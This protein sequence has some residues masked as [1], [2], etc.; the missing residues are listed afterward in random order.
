MKSSVKSVFN[1]I[2]LFLSFITVVAGIGVLF[3]AERSNSFIKVDILNEQKNIIANL[4]K[5]DK[6]DVEIALIQF[7]GKS[8][9]LLYQTQKLY[10]LHEYDIIGKYILKTSDEYI[11]QL[12]T[13]TQYIKDYNQN[14]YKYFKSKK[15]NETNNK[16][17]FLNSYTNINNHISNIIFTNIT[18]NK[19]KN[20]FIYKLSIGL[21]IL[22]LLFTFV[23]YIKL[24]KVYKD[25]LFLQNP[26]ADTD[27]HKIYSTE[28][29]SIYLRMN[30][31]PLKSQSTS[32]IDPITN[33]NNIQ[34]LQN[35]YIEKKEMK[36]SN[37]VC[38]AILEIDNFSKKN[39][40]DPKEFNQEFTR[41][42][43]KKIA[44]TITMYEQTTDSIARTDY[45]EFTIIL[46]RANKEKAFVEIDQIRQSISE[47]KFVSSKK[48]PV[49]ITVSGGFY[50]K[51]NSVTLNNA[52][53]ETKS[54]LEF[55]K[56]NNGN[57]ISKKKDI[58]GVKI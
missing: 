20:D 54:I 34:G 3:T 36:E 29:D 26:G 41:V 49:T 17:T 9:D 6:K 51:P 22:I 50:I 14:A 39:I 13:L 55:A 48:A 52:I 40:T 7:N 30:K 23:F 16:I 32:N 11:Y 57:K 27:K 31:R 47:L 37:F 38:V 58:V 53:L 18:Y 10:A 15:E 35:S 56:Q 1:N 8:T 4:Q 45:N 42:I 44:N 33:L 21:F 2:V 46:S 19:E 43:L 28:A 5:I 25:I 12:E 24:K